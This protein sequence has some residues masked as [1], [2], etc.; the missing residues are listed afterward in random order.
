MFGPAEQVLNAMRKTTDAKKIFKQELEIL[1]DIVNLVSR[2][3]KNELARFLQ[4]TL[5][6][7]FI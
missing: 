5:A 1:S 4:D 7:T 6:P 3:C 2:F